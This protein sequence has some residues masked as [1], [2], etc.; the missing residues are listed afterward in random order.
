MIDRNS[1]FPTV[2]KQKDNQIRQPENTF[3]PKMFHPESYEYLIVFYEFSI[4]PSSIFEP[5]S[6]FLMSFILYQKYQMTTYSNRSSVY[7]II[8]L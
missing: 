3:S 5:A 4:T 1:K 7:K 2:L 8:F 6:H